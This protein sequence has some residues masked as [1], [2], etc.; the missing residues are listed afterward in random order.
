[1]TLDTIE[2][3]GNPLLD[4]LTLQSLVGLRIKNL[5]TQLNASAAGNGVISQGPSKF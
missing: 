2:S 3:K 4:A 5:G 1:M